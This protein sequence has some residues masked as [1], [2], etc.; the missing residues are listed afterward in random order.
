MDK[1]RQMAFNLNNFLLAFSEILNSKKVAYIA[2]NLALKYDFSQEKLSDLCS[3]A[4]ICDL[5]KDDIKE[6]DFLNSS[7]LED[8]TFLDIVNL[9]LTICKNFDFSDD[10]LNQ[11]LSCIEFVKNL[12]IEDKLKDSFFD[13]SKKLSFWLDLQNDS[14]ILIFIYSNLA[15]FT[16]ALDFEDILKMTTIF[17][18]L[19]NPNSQILKYS[20]TLADYFNFE[21]KDK[22]IFLIASSLYNIGKLYKQKN[23]EIVYP[24]HTKRVLNQIMGFSDICALAYK[25]EEKLDGSG[26]FSLEAKD[27]SF[28]DRLLICL[29]RYS[30]LKSSFSHHEIIEILKEE[31][32]NGKIDKSIVDFLVVLD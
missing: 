21:H 29:V 7:H 14:E 28:K 4:L 3:Y 25:I 15:D 23:I 1:K 6:F 10:I 20:F 2:L 31:S 26:I 9:S 22:Q 32:E 17:H 18:K 27:L 30:N 8:K 11:K 12:N 16:K 5:K 24:Y 13:I 19:Q